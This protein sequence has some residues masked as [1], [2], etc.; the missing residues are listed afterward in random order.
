MDIVGEE[1]GR[2]LAC[3]FGTG[4]GPLHVLR[5]GVGAFAT[6]EN[7]GFPGVTLGLD[8]DAMLGL[9]LHYLRR[10]AELLE[11]HLGRT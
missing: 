3:M 11:Q 1:D 4:D 9:I 6:G 5:I 10:M 2:S 8:E 7:V